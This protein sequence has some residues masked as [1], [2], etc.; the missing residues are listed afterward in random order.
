MAI[1]LG[2]NDRIKLDYSLS[3]VLVCVVVN[4]VHEILNICTCN[5][6]SIN[7]LDKIIVNWK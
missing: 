7:V 4:R 3:L 2:L 5:L 6:S 1:V